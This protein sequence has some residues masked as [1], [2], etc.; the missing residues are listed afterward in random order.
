MDSNFLIDYGFD[1]KTI[2]MIK[3]YNSLPIYESLMFNED[4][5]KK[6][7]IYFR[8]LGLTCLKDLIVYRIDYFIKTYK[9]IVNIFSNVS[10]DAIIN[11]NNDY[12]L[13]DEILENK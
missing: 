13:I 6:I 4:E 8:K 2:E 12:T 1:I 9:E 7:I 5:C 11:I 3:E 10:H